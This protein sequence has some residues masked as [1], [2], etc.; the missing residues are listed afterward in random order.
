MLEIDS[1][2]L[3]ASGGETLFLFCTTVWM[4][5]MTMFS[6]ALRLLHYYK[7]DLAHILAFKN[8]VIEFL[9]AKI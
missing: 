8:L 1:L 5:I 6:V 9:N 3:P 4:K 7:I 2:V